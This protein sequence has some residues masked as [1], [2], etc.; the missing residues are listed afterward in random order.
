[1]VVIEDPQNIRLGR[2]F[3]Q[4]PYTSRDQREKT[5]NVGIKNSTSPAEVTAGLVDR[6][7]PLTKKSLQPA[8]G[9]EFR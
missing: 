2:L 6:W 3:F 8:P 9:L 7:W 5:H 4:W 1:M